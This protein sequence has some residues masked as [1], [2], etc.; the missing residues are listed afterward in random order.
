[1][2]IDSHGRSPRSFL[3]SLRGNVSKA[4]STAGSRGSRLLEI[5]DIKA[6]DTIAL[7]TNIFIYALNSSGDKGEKARV[8]LETIKELK[9]T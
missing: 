7:D 3:S 8:V 5:V 6:S 1:M 2:G 4:S 9:I